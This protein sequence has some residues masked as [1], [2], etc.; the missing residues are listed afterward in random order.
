MVG[1]KDLGFGVWCSGLG[2]WGWGVWGFDLGVWGVRGIRGFKV[3]VVYGIWGSM[4]L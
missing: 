3:L 1:V 2:V 4:G